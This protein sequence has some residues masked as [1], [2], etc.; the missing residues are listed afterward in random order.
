MLNEAPR[1]QFERNDNDW[2]LYSRRSSGQESKL[3]LLAV[4]ETAVAS[5]L[6]I[7]LFYNGF[8]WALLTAIVL[9]PFVHLR[10]PRSVNLGLKNFD[11]Y[12]ADGQTV[13]AAVWPVASLALLYSLG[14]LWIGREPSF[15]FSEGKYPLL[16]SSFGVFIL[17]FLPASLP[18]VLIV[19]WRGYASALSKPA[20]CSAA[21]LTGVTIAWQIIEGMQVLNAIIG[22]AGSIALSL[23]LLTFTLASRKWPPSVSVAA[24][25]VVLPLS[26]FGVF[27]RTLVIRF[28]ATIRYLLQGWHHFPENWLTLLTKVD[29]TSPVEI[30]PGAQTGHPLNFNTATQRMRLG[31]T[32][33]VRLSAYAFV[34][35]F[36]PSVFYRILLK[37]SFPFYAPVVW[38]AVRPAV[39]ET[40]NWN[41]TFGR[42]P[43]DYLFFTI[44]LATFGHS[45]FHFWDTERYIEAT[46]WAM[47]NDAP[48]FWPLM[49]AGI[50]SD[51]GSTWI[52]LPGITAG[53]AL[54]IYFWSLHVSHRFRRANI[55]P[56]TWQLWLIV[57]LHYLKS[58]LTWVMMGL[59]FWALFAY[60]SDTCQVP[61]YLEF[62]I[63]E[64]CPATKLPIPN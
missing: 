38:V 9:T 34:V 57:K 32:V 64:N 53:L 47:L 11:N 27:L 58:A 49:L 19:F 61:Y 36:F 59:G 23:V 25:V 5:A 26:M 48:N 2:V 41:D 15:L 28:F 35:L 56:K 7:I 55:H 8:Y 21:L 31:N 37:M 20:A 46:R 17:G 50:R 63:Y 22:N 30:L 29:L 60:L 14:L 51:G 52:L 62:L 39:V 54:I 13:D 42:G 24:F 1:P 33:L 10:S 18:V 45:A 4:T 12:W 44:S 6:G 16:E 43:L 3:S 40:G